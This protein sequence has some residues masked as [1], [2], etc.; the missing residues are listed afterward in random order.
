[1]TKEKSVC[2]YGSGR[3]RLFTGSVTAL[4]LGIGLVASSV[5]AE[6]SI[7]SAVINESFAN[8]PAKPAN[9]TQ[10]PR[11]KVETDF[12]GPYAAPLKAYVEELLMQAGRP[13][14]TQ[15]PAYDYKILISLVEDPQM[16]YNQTPTG[17]KENGWD[18][19]KKGVGLFGTIAN[20][21]GGTNNNKAATTASNITANIN[22]LDTNIDATL[23]CQ[24]RLQL[25]DSS[26]LVRASEGPELRQTNKLAA[27]ALELGG[28]SFG[29]ASP[30]NVAGFVLNLTN[31]NQDIAKLA[32]FVAATNLLTK[33]D[34]IFLEPLA[35]ATP[36]TP[37][38]PVQV[39]IAVQ[40]ATTPQPAAPAAENELLTIE[41]AAAILQ[42]P[43]PTVEE[44]IKKGELKVKKIG[45]LVRISRKDNGL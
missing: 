12:Q 36:I 43:V 31:R 11:A 26:G 29:G 6:T 45:P 33:A 9:L 20:A 23:S 35:V 13:Q 5:F 41:Q 39:S 17:R 16:V 42:V 22:L 10:V 3:S 14:I 19:L 34:R 24:V 1:M 40:P 8:L 7:S 32:A 21:K 37:P 25:L 28:A 15:G 18:L 27:F 38:P 44:M 30:E 4:L 2:T